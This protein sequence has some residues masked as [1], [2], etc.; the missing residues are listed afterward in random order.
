MPEEIQGELIGK[1]THYFANIGVA[2]LELSKKLNVGERIRLVGG[3]TDFIQTIESMEV[4]HKKVESAK[5]GES[6]GLKVDQK[7]RPDYRVYKV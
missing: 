7:V 2:V 1:V 3:E 5:P 4:D 6:I